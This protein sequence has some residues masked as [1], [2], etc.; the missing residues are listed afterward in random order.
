MTRSEVLN[1]V[2][3][4]FK[5][6]ELVCPDVYKRF[7]ESAWRFLDTNLLH[8]LLLIRRDILKT[9]ITVN[10]GSSFTQRG[11]RCNRCQLVRTKTTPYLSAHVLGKGIDFDAKGYTAAQS[12]EKIKANIDLFPFPIRL[13]DGVNWVHFDV[14]DM[15]NGQKLT[16]FTA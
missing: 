11:L 14:I 16:L 15:E 4:Y 13:E 6:Q 8:G 12:R 7:G 5:I 3:K 9:P 2:K 10:N 1:E